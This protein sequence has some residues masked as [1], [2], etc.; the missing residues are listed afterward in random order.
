V[1]DETFRTALLTKLGE[2][3]VELERSFEAPQDIEGCV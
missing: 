3:A 1:T 2:I